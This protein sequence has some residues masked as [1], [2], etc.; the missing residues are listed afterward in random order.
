MVK[1]PLAVDSDIST[2]KPDCACRR[3]FVQ[4]ST[5]GAERVGWARCCTLDAAH[6]HPLAEP[7]AAREEQSLPDSRLRRVDLQARG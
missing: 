2:F 6:A 1:A 5:Q 3:G 7:Q 4:A